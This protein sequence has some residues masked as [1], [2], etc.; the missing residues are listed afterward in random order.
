MDYVAFKDYMKNNK[1]KF[2]IF[3]CGVDTAYSDDSPD[4]ISFIF[5]GILSNG[6]LVVLDEEVRNNRDLNQPLAPSD[7]VT[8]LVAFLERN[9]KE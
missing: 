1:L 7:V 8:N 3:S 2:K 5:Q 6:K 9:R 4:T